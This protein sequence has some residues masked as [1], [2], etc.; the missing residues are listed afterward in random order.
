MEKVEN[1]LQTTEKKMIWATENTQL[2]TQKEE[3]K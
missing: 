2:W 3:Y 1:K